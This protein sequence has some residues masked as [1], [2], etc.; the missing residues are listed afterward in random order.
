MAP[1]FSRGQ[2]IVKKRAV[3]EYFRRVV[4]GRGA[5]VLGVLIILVL[6]APWL[7]FVEVRALDFL[8]DLRPPHQPDPHIR[9]ID[10]GADPHLYDAYR[11]PRDLPSNG[12]EVPRLAYAEGVRRLSRWGAKVIVFDVMFSRSCRY[13]D[14][15]LASAIRQAGNVIVAATTKTKPGAVGLRD[16][17]E[18]INKD[19]W[20]V[21]SPVANQPNETV[22][23]VPLVV[24][25]HDSDRTY[26]A[27]SLLAFQCFRGV[28][29]ADF[30]I[31]ESGWLETAGLKVPLLTGERLHLLA[32]GKPR[33]ESETK[34]RNIS[35]IQVV[36]GSNVRRTPAVSSWN[37]LLVN[38]AGREG[39]IPMLG[40][41]EVLE[42][43]DKQGRDYFRDKA[44]IIGRTD[45]DVHWTAVG[46]MPGV[47]IQANAL[48]TL[49]GGSFIRPI[50]SWGI[51]GLLAT[52][53]TLTSMG[54]RRFTGVR[55][56]AAMLV[57]LVAVIFIARESLVVWGIWIYP[58]CCI[59]GAFLTWGM[60]TVAE[61]D[62][63]TSMLTRFIPSFIGKPAT[64]ITKE[65]RTM[66][67][68][69]LFSDIRGYTGTAEQLSPVETMT[70]LNTYQSA[71]EDIVTRYGGTIVKTPGDAV[72]V[73]F[74]KE[75]RGC[76]HATSALLCGRE[77]LD[78]LPTM[79]PGWEV[80]GVKLDVGV[81]INAGEVAIGL[82]GN[83]HL[84][85][86]VIGDP[87]NVAQRLESMT[88]TLHCPLI[89]SESISEVLPDD[90]ERAYIDEVI[91]TGRKAPL[92]IYTTPDFANRTRVS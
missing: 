83:R 19:V 41:D 2:R 75:V 10:I 52:L 85:P 38:W 58:F 82:V 44:V 84:E 53:S 13:E 71:V 24:T 87:V 11:D 65:I 1:V 4:I 43:S 25:D 39:T 80:L 88:K 42:F 31:S 48:Q 81:G 63:V 14:Q 72:L 64:A 40:L 28:R 45:W 8:Y 61:S 36:S 86:T 55:G 20:A 26:Q 33:L 60:L 78:S 76:N 18:P 32:L 27:L 56:I 70:I 50:S 3:G 15:R 37:T 79:A 54:A 30:R 73:V 7:S 67:A 74:W 66:Q 6:V 89:F 51:L 22:R 59:F 68:S 62:K 17:V 29:P 9:V 12:C 77:I 34:A 16:P 49:I 91:V 5:I 90:I 47:E 92:K 57:L 69:I 21:G 46:S 35:G 23:A